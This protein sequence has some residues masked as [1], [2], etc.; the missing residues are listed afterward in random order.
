MNTF[1]KAYTYVNDERFSWLLNTFLK[2]YTSVDD[3]RFVFNSKLN[4]SSSTDVY[5]FKNVGS[6]G[7]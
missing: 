5:A 1:W 3:E 4:L 7:C 6:V 2:A